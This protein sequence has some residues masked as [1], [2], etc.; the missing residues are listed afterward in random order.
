MEDSWLCI[1]TYKLILFG[2]NI[3]MIRSI[4]VYSQLKYEIVLEMEI[5]LDFVF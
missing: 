2:E 1:S 3:E 4:L 5:T